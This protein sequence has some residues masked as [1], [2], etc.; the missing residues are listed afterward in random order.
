MRSRK[1]FNQLSQRWDGGG[2]TPPAEP[3][4]LPVLPPTTPPAEPVV[5]AVLT[6]YAELAKTDTALQSFLNTRI[7]AETDTAIQKALEKERLLADEKATEAEKLA[8]MTESEKQK[9]QLKKA[10]EEINKLKSEAN[11]RA[12]KDQ[13]MQIAN[14]KKIPASLIGLLPFEGLKAEDVANKIDEIKSIYDKAVSDGIAQ[15]LSGAGTP[16]GIGHG[17]AA[18][19]KDAYQKMSYAERVKFAQENPEAYKIMKEGK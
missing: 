4:A 6:D 9:Y 19:A 15:A 12:L 1:R 8:A 3:A 10:Q 5:P 18:V 17:G 11:T 13:A 2:A 7:K 14:E 16:A